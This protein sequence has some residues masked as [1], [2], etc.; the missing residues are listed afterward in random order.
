M[1]KETR[2]LLGLT[3]QEMAGHLGISRSQLAMIES[4]RR[5][6]A[7]NKYLEL[8]KIYQVMAPGTSDSSN[9]VE[10]A[11]GQ[12]EKL[13]LERKKLVKQQL[14]IHQFR[15]KHIKDRIAGFKA[16]QD[17]YL[18][19]SAGMKGELSNL[20]AKTRKLLELREA[21][22]GTHALKKGGSSLLELEMRLCACEAI[23]RFLQSELKKG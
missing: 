4:G 20:T 19:L 15:L 6:L 9:P 3:Q 5:D 1:L 21:E 8:L 2:I 7:T 14:D 22:M 13:S 10:K 11:P 12:A 16:K 17:S 23:I 18:R